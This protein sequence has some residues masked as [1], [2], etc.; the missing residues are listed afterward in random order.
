MIVEGDAVPDALAQDARARS[1]M[2]E[3]AKS[4]SY[5][6]ARVLLA[7]HPATVAALALPRTPKSRILMPGA[8]D[9]PYVPCGRT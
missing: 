8:V 6:E 3:G 5:T 4:R 9:I 7:R 2:A 1:L